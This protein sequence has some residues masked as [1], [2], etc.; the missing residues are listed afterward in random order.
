MDQLPGQ[1]GIL[2]PGIPHCGRLQLLQGRQA[3]AH[4]PLPLQQRPGG[5]QWPLLLY[6]GRRYRLEPRLAAHPDRAG[7][8]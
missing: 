3:A 8:L 2:Q 4:H 7:Q 5:L 1:R 6:Q